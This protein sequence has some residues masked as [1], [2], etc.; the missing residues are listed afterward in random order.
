MPPKA[1]AKAA[2]A[3][4]KTASGSDAKKGQVQTKDEEGEFLQMYNLQMNM[5]TM[6]NCRIFS[7]VMAGCIAGL[8]KIEGLAGVLVW[9]VVT[10]LHSVMI[11]TKMGFS[12]TR[13][14]PK[15]RDVFVSQLMGGMMSF[16]LF[17]T[18]AYDIVHIF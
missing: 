17:W 5:R 8:L 15:S 16:I 11:F 13:Y 6:S 7:G 1:G 14:F 3:G 4:A 12:C 10:L 2:Q 9:I 18:L